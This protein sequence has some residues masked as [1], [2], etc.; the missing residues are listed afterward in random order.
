MLNGQ[1]FSSRTGRTSGLPKL[2][3]YKLYNW[4]MSVKGTG[5]DLPKER[6]PKIRISLWPLSS[7]DQKD[8]RRGP[9]HYRFHDGDTWKSRG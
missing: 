5:L 3:Y 2:N 7:P 1:T 6:N 4:K 8:F 9:E